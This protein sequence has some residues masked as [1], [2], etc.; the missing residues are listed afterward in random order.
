MRVLR[1][2]IGYCGSQDGN[3]AGAECC[4]S[5]FLHL[6]GSGYGN[7]ADIPGAGLYA[8]RSQDKRYIPAHHGSC[9]S[10]CNPHAA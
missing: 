2:E 9:L 6:C 10:E 4:H 5:G 8:D 3:I 7:N 1:C